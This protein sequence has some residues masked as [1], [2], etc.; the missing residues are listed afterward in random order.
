MKPF[1]GNSWQQLYQKQEYIIWCGYAFEIICLK[2]STEIKRA[3]KIEGLAS[4]NYTWSNPNTHVGMVIDRD[5]NWANLCEMK[6]YNEEYTIDASYL[7]R[8]ETKKREFKA[9]KTGR[10]GLYI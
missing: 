3:L 8:L 7:K 5:D 4:K 10:K 1:K 2:H 6:F 9:D